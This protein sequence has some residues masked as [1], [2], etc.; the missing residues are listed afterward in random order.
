[1]PHHSC[2]RRWGFYFEKYSVNGSRSRGEPATAEGR[3]DVGSTSAVFDLAAAR[4]DF[5]G[6]RRQRVDNPQA[7]LAEVVTVVSALQRFDQFG[8]SLFGEIKNLVRTATLHQQ[9]GA[10]SVASLDNLQEGSGFRSEGVRGDSGEHESFSSDGWVCARLDD[11]HE[12][13]SNKHI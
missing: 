12:I 8:V 10:G 7:V 11:R 9:S 4:D 2:W 1:L 6:E 5:S 3:R 13:D